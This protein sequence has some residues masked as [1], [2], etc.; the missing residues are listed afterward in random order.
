MSGDDIAAVFAM[1][2]S[3]GVI[4]RGLGRS[5]GDAALNDGGYVVDSTGMTRILDL[6]LQAGT[7]R[8]EAGVSVAQLL[9]LLAPLGWTL[10]VVT[11]TRHVTVGGAIAAD[12]HGKNH[13]RVGSWARHLERFSLQTPKGPFEVDATSEPDLFWATTGGMGLTGIVVDATLRIARAPTMWLTTHVRHARSL[14]NVVADL[15]DLASKHTYAVAWIDGLASG[16]RLGRGIAIGADIAP[17]D[18]LGAEARARACTFR[19]RHWFTAPRTVPSR[20]LNDATVRAANR[21]WLWRSSWGASPRLLPIDA[22]LMPLDAVSRWSHLY[23]ARGFVQ[24]QFAVPSREVDVLGAVITCLHRAKCPSY[25]TTLKRLGAAGEGLL[26]FPL[27]GWSLSLDI[28]AGRPAL[29]PILDELD[30]H[31]VGAGG[32][33]YLAKDSRLRRE[34]LEAMYPRI[35]Q[36]REVCKRVDP[37]GV[38]QSDL[39]RRLGIR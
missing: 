17:L 1:A 29:L 4:G 24:Y 12:V 36:F 26:S 9:T 8:V 14:E 19:P 23:G 28:P 38:L 18:A 35:D 6:D 16:S 37:R 15:E 34:H 13:H 21:C 20:L 39:S 31:V 11:A 3:M 2:G 22:G 5:Y 32:R 25:F 30:S 7:V 33:V 10:P 27:R